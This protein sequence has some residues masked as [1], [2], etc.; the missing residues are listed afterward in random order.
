[1]TAFLKYLGIQLKLDLREKGTLLNFYLVPLVFFFVMG[2]V[3]TSINP[4]M[5]TTLAATMTIFAVTMGAVM[6]TPAYLV[7]L[8]QSGTL[9]A[10]RV[11]GISGG[12][13]IAVQAVGAFVHLFAVSAIIY[14][15][16]VIAFHSKYPQSPAAYFA[17]LA[18]YLFTSVSI[19][20]LIGAVSRDQSMATML[21]MVV[22][23]M[24]LLL[25]GIMFPAKMLPKTFVY[26]G[27]V[28]PATHALQSFYGFA[29]H[30]KTDID[31]AISI[32]IVAGTGIVLLALAIF[33]FSSIR[34]TEQL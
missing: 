15:G 29:Y 21:S 7:K 24:S 8:R 10:F 27:R 14:F 23:L 30:T 25:S 4:V 2:S 12:Y 13:V 34:K 31:P 22:F 32:C 11:N 20:L 3:F 5:K 17:V 16:S 1:M 26:V 28:F 33:R 9:R 19:G 18:V 6:G